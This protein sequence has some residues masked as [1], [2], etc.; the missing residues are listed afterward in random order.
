[1]KLGKSIWRYFS[2]RRKKTARGGCFRVR[3]SRR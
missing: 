1:M 2:E 3:N